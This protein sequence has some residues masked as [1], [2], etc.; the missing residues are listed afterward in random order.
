M[1]K[2]HVY[3]IA[4]FNERTN[5]FNM[6]NDKAVGI[7]L[8]WTD[9]GEH[10]AFIGVRQDD[11]NSTMME[12]AHA[13]HIVELGAPFPLKEAKSIIKDFGKEVYYE[14]PVQP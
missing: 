7:A 6:L 3:G 10:R 2:P 9:K 5:R 11:P 1:T 12:E 4:W 14:L 8:A 13:H